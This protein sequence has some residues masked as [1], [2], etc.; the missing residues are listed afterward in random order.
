MVVGLCGRC[1]CPVFCNRV[2]HCPL[3]SALARRL[4]L[5]A[6]YR[7][8]LRQGAPLVYQRRVLR[9]LGINYMEVNHG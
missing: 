7:R 2:C 3:G 6:Q 1:R 9:Q 5:L 4:G 8:L